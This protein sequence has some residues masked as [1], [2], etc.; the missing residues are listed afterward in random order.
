[1]IFYYNDNQKKAF[2]DFHNNETIEDF[3]SF[4]E[5]V[6]KA[7]DVFLDRIHKN[8]KLIPTNS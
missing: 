1:M 8:K 6:D 3:E 4:S 2:M 5:A 7:F